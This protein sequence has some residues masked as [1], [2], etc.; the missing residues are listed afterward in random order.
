MAIRPM[1]MK[2]MQEES[3]YQTSDLALATVLSLSYP[4]EATDKSNPRK[5]QFIFRRDKNLDALIE[6][7]WRGEVRVEP[8]IYFQQ[9]RGMKARIYND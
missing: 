8:Q 7:Y 2:M 5:A 6:D 4:I 1:N 9:L 3:F